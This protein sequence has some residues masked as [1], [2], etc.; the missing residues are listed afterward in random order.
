M[1]PYLVRLYLAAKSATS[2]ELSWNITEPSLF[3]SATMSDEKFPEL[4]ESRKRN[5]T[6]LQTGIQPD[7]GILSLEFYSRLGIGNFSLAV[8]DP[9]DDDMLLVQLWDNWASLGHHV[10]FHRYTRSQCGN[11]KLW[12]RNPIGTTRW[13]YNDIVHQGNTFIFRRCFPPTFTTM[14]RNS[15]YAPRPSV[16]WFDLASP[17]S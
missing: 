6:L 16:P 12:S 14:R 5:V 9:K 4:Y 3:P 8:W 2:E 17:V 13:P 11:R 7:K 10:G 15:N 1:S